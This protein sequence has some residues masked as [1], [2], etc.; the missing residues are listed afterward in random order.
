MDLAKGW[1][2]YLGPRLR[3]HMACTQCLKPQ[4]SEPNLHTYGMEWFAIGFA[5]SR[6]FFCDTFHT[7]TARSFGGRSLY[8]G[9]VMLWLVQTRVKKCW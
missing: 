9:Q 7:N 8:K 4:K 1:R 6:A 3:S 5:R 2:I